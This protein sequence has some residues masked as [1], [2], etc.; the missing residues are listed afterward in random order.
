MNTT[1]R[2]SLPYLHEGVGDPPIS[3]D[4]PLTPLEVMWLIFRVRCYPGAAFATEKV[5]NPA[6]NPDAFGVPRWH[7]IY[8]WTAELIGIRMALTKREDSRTALNLDHYALAGQ[9]W[10]LT[11]TF[12]RG[13]GLGPRHI[14]IDGGGHGIVQEA[15]LTGLDDFKRDYALLKLFEGA[16]EAA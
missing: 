4:L 9:D 5:R 3:E 8:R 1:V 6:W 2:W 12:R 16:A 14:E 10:T 13:G 11:C 7:Y 15:A